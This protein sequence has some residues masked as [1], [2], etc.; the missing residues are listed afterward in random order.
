MSYRGAGCRTWRLARARRRDRPDDV[1]DTYAARCRR[2]AM[3]EAAR[4]EECVARVVDLMLVR[5]LLPSFAW[6][7][8]RFPSQSPFAG[9]TF[10]RV[11]LVSSS[12]YKP[13][14][15]LLQYLAHEYQNVKSDALYIAYRHSERLAVATARRAGAVTHRHPST[16]S[17]PVAL[18]Y[19]G[20]LPRP[21]VDNVHGR[22]SSPAGSR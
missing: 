12:S 3:S 16:I 14:H 8:P 6:S 1:G 21:R 10:V 4:R 2:S 15:P 22:G 17:H 5:V 18:R 19:P 13:M 9:R 20:L 11:P 7:T